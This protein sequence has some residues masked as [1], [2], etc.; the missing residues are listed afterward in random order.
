MNMKITYKSLFKL[1]K[2]LLIFSLKD[3]KYKNIK[4]NPNESI[5]A[6]IP[7]STKEGLYK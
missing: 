1:L 4:N 2:K 7:L 3:N 6:I 5:N